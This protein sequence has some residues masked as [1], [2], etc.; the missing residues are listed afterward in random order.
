MRRSLE[1]DI[2]ENLSER[3]VRLAL[4]RLDQPQTC[5]H[6]L[7]EVDGLEFASV[8]ADIAQRF[9]IPLLGPQGHELPSVV[10]EVAVALPRDESAARDDASGVERSAELLPL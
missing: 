1:A 3:I 10:Q 4:L 6:L 5:G 9:V 2:G 7:S 8:N